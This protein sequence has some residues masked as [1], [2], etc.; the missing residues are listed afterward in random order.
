MALHFGDFRRLACR[1]ISAS[2]ELRVFFWC[3]F[4]L[5]ALDCWSEY[6]RPRHRCLSIGESETIGEDLLT[7]DT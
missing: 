2:A 1:A 4:G 7:S 5:V 3:Q 6:R